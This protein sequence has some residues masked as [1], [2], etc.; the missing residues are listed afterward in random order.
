MNAE[1]FAEWLRRQGHKI[2]RTSSSYWYNAGPHV[3]QAFPYHWLITPGEKEIHTLMLKH[4]IVALRYSAPPDYH[5]GKM[6]YHIVQK[7]CYNLQMLNP[8]ARNG[9]KCGLK[10][11][12][13]E[14]IS[15]ERLALEGW[16]LQQD[17]LMRQNRLKSMNRDE[18]EVLCRAAVNLPGFEAFAAISEGELAGAL[19]VCHINDVYTVPYAMSHCRFLRG[20]VN[21]ALFYRVSCELLNRENNNGIFFTVQSLDAPENVDEFKLRMGFEP[22]MVRQNVVIHPYLKP[23]ITPSV[24]KVNRKLLKRYPSNPFLAKA[25]GMLRFHLEG[26]RPIKEQTWPNCLHKEMKL[27]EFERDAQVI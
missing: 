16:V 2:Y 7:N 12:N 17:T 5:E 6:S 25:E 3:L 24:Y 8:K 26:R 15:F 4:G 11:F 20:H 27:F 21:N 14:Q 23:F 18:W 10:N 19:I 1:I 9:V 13:V 22:K